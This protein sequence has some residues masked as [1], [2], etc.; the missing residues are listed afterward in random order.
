MGT[1][2]L[3]ETQWL[4]QHLNDPQLRIFDCTVKRWIDDGVFCVERGNAEYEK[5]HIPGAAH[6]DL[7]HDLSDPESTLRFAL[8]SPERFADAVSG[9]GVSND[10]RVVLYG[11]REIQYVTRVWWMFQVFGFKNVVLL[12]GGWQAW[13]RENRPVTTDRPNHPPG[14]FTPRY[15][16]ELVADKAAVLA[17][18]ENSATCLINALSPDLHSGKTHIHFG[19]RGL[20]SRPGRIPGSL[21]L[22]SLDLIDRETNKFLPLPVLREK[23]NGLGVFDKDGVI[24]Y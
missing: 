19:P 8:P 9:H 21:N 10:S 14:N 6:L 18:M 15:K 20:A 16:Q 13:S 5:G 11:T 22:W 23:F 2:Y 12:D 7:V 17:A 4:E 24:F 1:D 3:V